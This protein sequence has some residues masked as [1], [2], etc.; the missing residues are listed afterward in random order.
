MQ[1]TPCSKLTKKKRPCPFLGDR[2]DEQGNPVCH[3][4]DQNGKYQ[5]MVRGEPIVYKKV[6]RVIPRRFPKQPSSLDPNWKDA[7]PFEANVI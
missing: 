5:R 7:C 2:R 3:I 6:F 1:F 4:H